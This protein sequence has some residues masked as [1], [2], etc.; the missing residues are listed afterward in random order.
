MGESEMLSLSVRCNIGGFISRWLAIAIRIIIVNLISGRLDLSRNVHPECIPCFWCALA[1]ASTKI[2]TQHFHLVGCFSLSSFRSDFYM[3]FFRE[4]KQQ[5]CSFWL[6][7]FSWLST[8]SQQLMPHID[9]PTATVLAYNSNI[10]PRYADD[11]QLNRIQ[12]HSIRGMSELST[13]VVIS[14]NSLLTAVLSASQI[15]K[16]TNG[17]RKILFLRTKLFEIILFIRCRTIEGLIR[18]SLWEYHR[19]L[20]ALVVLLFVA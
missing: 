2:C 16:S 7:S 6:R 17:L 20:R 19:R 11:V 4:K 14:V 13:Y 12:L 1:L 10:N 9:R 3:P 5:H 18:V 8:T 15:F